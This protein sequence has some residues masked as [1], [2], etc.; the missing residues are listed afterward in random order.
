MNVHNIYIYID[1]YIYIYICIEIYIDIYIYMYVYIIY[2]ISTIYSLVISY[3]SGKSPS[4]SLNSTNCP[5]VQ[6]RYVSSGHMI[7][8]WGVSINGGS[9]KIRDLFPGKSPSKWMITR[10]VPWKPPHT[11][12][13]SPPSPLWIPPVLTAPA[14][15]R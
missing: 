10:G 6:C 7:S 9:P 13:P 11:S 4:L 2:N 1:I 5:T 8:T 12:H 15:A 14:D 3:S